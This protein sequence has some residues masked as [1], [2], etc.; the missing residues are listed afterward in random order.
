MSTTAKACPHC[1]DRLSWIERLCR[2]RKTRRA[3]AKKSEDEQW[4][5]DGKDVEALD[6]PALLQPLPHH[7]DQ[8]IVD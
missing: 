7:Q 1:G 5:D 8:F 3:E 2:D 6:N 4:K